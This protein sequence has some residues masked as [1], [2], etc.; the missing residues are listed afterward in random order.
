MTAPGRITVAGS[1]AQKPHQ[2]GHSWQFLQYLLGFRRLGWDV[3]FVDRLESRLCRDA[4]G[5]ACA[6]EDSVNL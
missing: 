4:A 1:I 6:P 3:L 2:A 5:R